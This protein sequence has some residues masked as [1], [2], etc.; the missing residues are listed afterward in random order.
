MPRTNDSNGAL[1]IIRRTPKFMWHYM[2]TFFDFDGALLSA[3]KRCLASLSAIAH[4]VE[5]YRTLSRALSHA[6]ARYRP[7]Y[8]L[9]SRTLSHAHTAPKLLVLGQKTCLMMQQKGLGC[10]RKGAFYC[11][12]K[13]LLC[14]NRRHHMSSIAMKSMSSHVFNRQ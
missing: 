9:L 2:G 6:I 3:I 12:R 11:D 8:R 4:L 7:R 1:L 10:N 5:C 13:H 14:C